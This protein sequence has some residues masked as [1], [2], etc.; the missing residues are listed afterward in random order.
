MLE[1]SSSLPLQLLGSGQLLSLSPH[2]QGWLILQKPFY[3]EFVGPGAAIGGSFDVQCK[4]IFAIGD[5][6]FVAPTTLAEKK[7]AFQVRI[8]SIQLLHE[9]MQEISPLQRAVLLVEQL[10]S[11]LGIGLA[12]EIPHELA[13]QLIGVMPHNLEIAWNHYLKC[14]SLNIPSALDPVLA[15][16]SASVSPLRLIKS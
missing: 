1:T 15:G 11:M 7:Q 3:T 13:A 16:E 8:N 14:Q 6:Q 5:V 12:Q 4:S 9:L 10:C 2:H